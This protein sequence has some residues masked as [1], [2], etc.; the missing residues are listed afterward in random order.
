MKQ[1]PKVAEALDGFSDDEVLAA[2]DR[3]K[4][5]KVAERPVKQVELDALLA[6]ARGLRRRRPDRPRLPRAPAARPRSGAA[7]R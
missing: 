6:A 5:G 2:I 7:R 1:R 4:G 3:L